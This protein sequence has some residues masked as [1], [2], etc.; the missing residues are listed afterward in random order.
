MKLHQDSACVR[1]LGDLLGQL[2]EAVYEAFDKGEPETPVLEDLATLPAP[3][4]VLTLFALALSDYQLG[5]GGAEQYWKDV[6]DELK[7][8]KP[9]LVEDVKQLMERMVQ[10]P[11][12]SRLAQQKLS[13]IDRL[14]ASPLALWLD[15]RSLTELATDPMSLWAQLAA[16]M[17]TSP[18]TKTVALAIKMFDLFHK[19]NAGSYVRFPTRVPIVVDLRIGRISVSSG[20][21]RPA[22]DESVIALMSSANAWVSEQKEVVLDAWAEVARQPGEISL[23]RIDSLAWQLAEPIYVNRADRVAAVSAVGTILRALGTKADLTPRLCK[24]LTEAL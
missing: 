11:S 23:F 13:R 21:L 19:L 5:A 12:A 8:K 18:N 2:P 7:D 24:A 3:I 14:L 6:A 22:S 9:R 4:G 17:N 10:H 15:G 16:A 1:E 20:L